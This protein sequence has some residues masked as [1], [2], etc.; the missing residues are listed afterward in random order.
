MVSILL[1]WQRSACSVAC[2]AAY[3]SQSE[4]RRIVMNIHAE[5]GLIVGI[6][7]YVSKRV[8]SGSIVPFVLVSPMA[9]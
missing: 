7:Q 2:T 5:A 6:V 9:Y 4:P 3:T 8:P 1:Y